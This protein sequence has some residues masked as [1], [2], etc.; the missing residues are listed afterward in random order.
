MS[1]KMGD[2]MQLTLKDKLIATFN[3]LVLPS[4]LS[5][6]VTYALL[7]TGPYRGPLWLAAFVVFVSL[8]LAFFTV[9]LAVWMFVSR[10]I[11]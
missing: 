9:V 5:A 4:L 1:G 6:G 3:L 7:A 10:T 2:S 8:Y 11:L